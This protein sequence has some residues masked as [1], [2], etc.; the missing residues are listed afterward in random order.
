M[1][2]R[3]VHI[4]DDRHATLVETTNGSKHANATYATLSYCWGGDHKFKAKKSNLSLLMGKGFLI[5][6]LP[7]VLRE[8]IELCRKLNVL[9]IWIDA[10]CITQD[11]GDDWVEESARM[12]S[13]YQNSH[14]TIAAA[15][16]ASVGMSYLGDGLVQ[17]RQPVEFTVPPTTPG[18]PPATVSARREPVAWHTRALGDLEQFFHDPLRLRGWALQE[19]ILA[20][21][22]VV[23][24]AGEMQ[25]RCRTTTACE[26]G[27]SNFIYSD[28]PKA[29]PEEDGQIPREQREGYVLTMFSFWRHDVVRRYGPRLLTYPQD[30]LPALSGM[31]QR[32]SRATGG[33]YVAG[34]WLETLIYDMCWQNTFLKGVEPFCRDYTAPTFSWCSVNGLREVH[35]WIHYQNFTPDAVVV[36]V[37]IELKHTGAPFGALVDGHVVLRDRIAPALL[38]YIDGEYHIVLDD[39]TQDH[40]GATYRERL[41]FCPDTH[42]Q[43]SPVSASSPEDH[44]GKARWTG[45]RTFEAPNGVHAEIL[46]GSPD[47]GGCVVWMLLLGTVIRSCD[48]VEMQCILVLGKS[49][50]RPGAYERLGLLSTEGDAEPQ[51]KPMKNRGWTETLTIV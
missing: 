25:W 16:S 39:N 7:A 22:L 35:R 27:S 49:A 8:T 47:F 11:D 20:R 24:G 3:L 43:A 32:V 26:C 50:R 6:S 33:T 40:S 9:Y 18:C 42:V 4:N 1:P 48:N 15:S 23:F 41:E 31:A 12:G 2:K 19:E 5:A 13:I 29:P 44:Q 17:R 10:L 30:I 46:G 37:N 14:L 38:E 28:W 36:D 51:L 45:T 21:R 34:M